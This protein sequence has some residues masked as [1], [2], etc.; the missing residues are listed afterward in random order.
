MCSNLFR[1]ALLALL[2]LVGRQSSAGALDY[3]VI[4]SD[5]TSDREWL[6][7]RAQYE[8]LDADF[9]PGNIQHLVSPTE[10]A[11]TTALSGAAQHRDLTLIL[12][13][14][15]RTNASGE[16]VLAVG[17]RQIRASALRA[18]LDELQPT[19]AGQALVIQDGDY[20][21]TFIKPLI[22]PAYVSG[23]RAL[24]GSSLASE[25]HVARVGGSISL[26]GRVLAD[27]FASPTASLG[28]L[29]AS[30][31]AELLW[32]TNAAVHPFKVDTDGAIRSTRDFLK[33]VFRSSRWRPDAPISAGYRPAAD[34]A[35]V[36]VSDADSTFYGANAAA[37]H[38]LET[39][40]FRYSQVTWLAPPSNELFGQ[41]DGAPSLSGIDSALIGATGAHDV[42]VFVAG[43]GS[44]SSVSL[45]SA[46]RLDYPYLASRLAKLQKSLSGRLTVVL[47][48]CFAGAFVTEM[49][50]ASTAGAYPNGPPVVI[51]SAGIDAKATFSLGALGFDAFWSERVILG[52]TVAQATLRAADAIALVPLGIGNPPQIPQLDANGNGIANEPADYAS[53]GY[54]LLPRPLAEE[55]VNG[56]CDPGFDPPPVY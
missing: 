5:G 1:S 43:H 7:I 26:L 12:L 15:A 37:I 19:L 11:L 54:T 46:T 21:E 14:D 9:A 52:E 51:A 22:N 39:L 25:R 40:G 10:L 50:K 17:A 29:A 41:P 53:A 36:L 47:D 3:A 48:S 28:N 49:A 4:V 18:T 38:A 30:A 13:G 44:T 23:A 27:H 16:I 42:V 55:C 35:I 31:T 33:D 2:L 6:A 32:M 34:R 56:F 8:L 20:A 24:M 45:N